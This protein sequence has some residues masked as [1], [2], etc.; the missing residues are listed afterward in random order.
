MEAQAANEG[1]RRFGA[2]RFDP[3]G[4]LSA[5]DNCAGRQGDGERL[6]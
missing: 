1:Q 2:G 6:P 5:G 4:D 3:G